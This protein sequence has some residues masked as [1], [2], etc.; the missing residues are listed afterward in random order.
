MP[1]FYNI[2]IL[3]LLIL[4]NTVNVLRVNQQPSLAQPDHYFFPRRLSIRD[5]KRL[6]E[7][8]SGIL[9]IGQL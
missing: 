6:L 3:L 4:Y 8:G 7:I 5:Y 1:L 2:I 9:P